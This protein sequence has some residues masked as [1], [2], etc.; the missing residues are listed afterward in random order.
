MVEWCL[1]P[2]QTVRRLF[3]NPHLPT[4]PLFGAATTAAGPHVSALAAPSTSHYPKDC[5]L[6]SIAGDGGLSP[7]SSSCITILH[8]PIVQAGTEGLAHTLRVILAVLHRER[9]LVPLQGPT[10]DLLQGQWVLW[11]VWVLLVGVGM[12]VVCGLGWLVTV[13]LLLLLLLSLLCLMF[14]SR[15][16]LVLDRYHSSLDRP[17]F[18]TLM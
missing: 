9:S 18:K 13:V 5:D 1:T 11:I 14:A 12:V 6:P 16:L 2:F 10:V 3:T 8:L 7:C 15:P 4:Y 17:L